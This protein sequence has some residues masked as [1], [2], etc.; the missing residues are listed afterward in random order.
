MSIPG[1][2]SAP[3]TPYPHLQP[4][5]V[6]DSLVRET[7]RGL[8]TST[9]QH[10]GSSNRNSNISQKLAG[11]KEVLGGGSRPR[12]DVLCTH[13]AARKGPP[14][15]GRGLLP[16]EGSHLFLQPAGILHLFRAMGAHS[17][18][19]IGGVGGPP[20]SCPERVS[21]FYQGGRLKTSAPCPG[22]GAGG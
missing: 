1:A 11:R 7:P 14:V 4:P 13:A 8:L 5:P 18:S 3:P 22:R 20:Q 12:G 15:S 2:K 19:N 9:A 21:F 6:A 17:A 16:A 10:R